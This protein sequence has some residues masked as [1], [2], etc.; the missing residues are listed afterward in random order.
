MNKQKQVKRVMS[1]IL[2]GLFLFCG[3]LFWGGPAC[4]AAEE[5][6]EYLQTHEN[7]MTYEVQKKSAARQKM[8]KNQQL[9]INTGDGPGGDKPSPTYRQTRPT[10]PIQSQRPTRPAQDMRPTAP[11]QSMRP[12]APVRNMRPTVPIQ[13]QR[14][15]GPAQNIRPTAPN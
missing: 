14:P 12:T 11:T 15:T 7:P 9:H 13:S 10:I 3:V 1:L 4:C 6:E 5:E 2:C 8:E